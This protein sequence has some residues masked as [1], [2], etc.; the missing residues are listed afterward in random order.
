MFKIGLSGNI[1][2]GKSEVEKLLQNKGFQVI[3]LDKISH[4]FLDEDEKIRHKI[5]IEFNTLDRKDLSKIVFSNS[6]KRKILENIVHPELKNFIISLNSKE[7][8]FISGALIYEAGFDNLFNK[9]IFVDAPYETRLQRLMKRNNIDEKTAQTI[10]NCQNDNN[11]TKADYI[12]QNNS[13]IEE[14]NKNLD[15]VLNSINVTH[16]IF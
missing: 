8:V 11:K 15:E 10:M 9:I 13:T 6:K 2:S 7:T 12:I 16:N 14:L 3:D 5:Y 4:K 1:A